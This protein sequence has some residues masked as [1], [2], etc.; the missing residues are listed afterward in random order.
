M[1]RRTLLALA[2]LPAIV[3]AD[4]PLAMTA[5]SRVANPAEASGFEVREKINLWEPKQTAIIICDMWDDHWCKSAAK[6]CAEIAP[7]MNAVVVE[8]RKRGIFVIHAPSDCM[9]FYKGAPQRKLAQSAPDAKNLPKDVAAGCRQLPNEPALAVDASDGGCDDATPGKVN[10]R[11]WKRQHEAIK[12]HDDDAI[13]DSGKE[14]WNL[15]EARGITNVLLMGVHTNMCVVGRPFGLRQMVKNGKNVVL[16]R[17][18][19]DAMYNP[20]KPPFV[21]HRRGTEMIIA[22]IEAH[23]CP[24]VTA[25]DITM[26][27]APMHVAFVIG[28]DEYKTEVSLPRFAKEELEK[29]NVRCTFIYADAKDKNSFPEIA[30]IKDADLVVISVRRR[31]PPSDQLAVLREYVESGRPLVGIR[32]ASHAFALRDKPDGWPQFDKDVLGGNY[33]MHYPNDPKNGP[34]TVVAQVETSAKHPILTGVAGEFQSKGSLY[35]NASLAKSATPLLW[36]KVGTN[37]NEKELVAWTN[38]C[39]GGRVFY[40]SLG[41]IEDFQNASF[42]RLLLNGIFWAMERGAP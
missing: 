6:R 18:L 42:R 40:T 39:K 27:P 12:I 15:M 1:F 33:D 19:T 4:P 30:K 10:F 25:Q 31:V 11:A 29:R 32:T 20:A 9:E 26:H 36:G 2:I 24:S 41:Y 38:S 7:R 3:R 23:I 8:A 35:R 22:H 16:V 21:A 28:E 17:D 5:R 14:I 34:P 13:S 37:G